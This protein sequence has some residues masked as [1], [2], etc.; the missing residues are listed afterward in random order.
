[1]VFTIAAALLLAVGNPW[2]VALL[3]GGG[4]FG[5]TLPLINGM[6]PPSDERSG[7]R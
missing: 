3:G 2:P 4:A 6:I 7:S 5:M 1:M